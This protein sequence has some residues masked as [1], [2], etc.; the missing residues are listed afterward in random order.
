MTDSLECGNKVATNARHA[1]DA[2]V[3]LAWPKYTDNS[4]TKIDLRD[5]DPVRELDAAVVAMMDFASSDG[6]A[7]T[8]KP[9]PTTH[10]R[11]GMTKNLKVPDTANH[12]ARKR[13]DMSALP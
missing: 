13:A 10:D 8:G 1:L 2:F 6:K 12:L 3:H 5:R 4:K 7:H 9:K 11:I